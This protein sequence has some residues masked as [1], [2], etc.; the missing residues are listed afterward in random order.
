MPPPPQGRE[1][2]TYIFWWVD[3]GPGIIYVYN[4]CPHIFTAGAQ[5]T[6]TAFTNKLHKTLGGVPFWHILHLPSSELM[7]LE[8]SE[9]VIQIWQGAVHGWWLSWCH[10]IGSNHMVEEKR[11]QTTHCQFYVRTSKTHRRLQLQW[12]AKYL[13]TPN[14]TISKFL[15]A[16]SHIYEYKCQRE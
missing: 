13:K 8:G 5:F 10:P 16:K 12:T 14:T 11:W 3:S 15:K 9:D 1:S 7:P 2:P 6:I 4:S